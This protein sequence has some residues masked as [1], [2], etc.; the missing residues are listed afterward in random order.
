MKTFAV[1]VSL[2]IL[3]LDVHCAIENETTSTDYVTTVEPTSTVTPTPE[4]F[5]AQHNSSCNDCVKSSA[6]CYYCYKNEQ[7]SYYPYSHLVPRYD[8]CGSLGDM[9]WGTC[10]INFEVLIISLELLE[11]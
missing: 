7:C 2:A 5:C 3:T 4:E 11:V 1:L 9:A 8:E 6:K 10:L